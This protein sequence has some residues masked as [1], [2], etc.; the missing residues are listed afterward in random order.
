MTDPKI[1]LIVAMTRSRVI[2]RDATLPWHLPAE[3]QLF[4][5]LTLGRTVLM[6]R[7]TFASIGRPLPERHNIIV[8]R[9]LGEVPGAEVHSSFDAALAAA[10]RRGEDVFILGGASIYRLAL[11]LADGL[12]ISWIRADYPGNIY[13][14]DFDLGLWQAEQ[15]EE[16]PEFT[17]AFYRRAA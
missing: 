10:R 6:G 5:R 11:P 16:Y 8:S 14:P 15:V 7:R 17:H 13:F 12:Y 3:L 4:K 1:Y 2:G 9:T